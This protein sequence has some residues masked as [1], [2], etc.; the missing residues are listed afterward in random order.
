MAK[1]K[2]LFGAKEKNEAD[3]TKKDRDEKEFWHKIYMGPVRKRENARGFREN[4]IQGAGHRWWEKTT[5]SI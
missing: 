2:S 4:L 1:Q 5:T 3:V